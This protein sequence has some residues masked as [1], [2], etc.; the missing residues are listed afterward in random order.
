[1]NHPKKIASE[2]IAICKKL[3][4]I[5]GEK[6]ITHQMIADNVGIKRE[7]VSRIFSGRFSVGID[8]LIAIGKAVGCE[9]KIIEKK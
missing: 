3:S 5:A 8:L 6:G 1:M 4:E 9:V 2:R 7:S